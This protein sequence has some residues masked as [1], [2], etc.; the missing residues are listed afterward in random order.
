MNKSLVCVCAALCLA[1]VGCFRGTVS[2]NAPIHLNPNMDDQEKYEVYE[3]SPLF[4]DG[5]SMRMPVWG[6]LSNDE[7]AMPDSFHTGKNEK[8]QWISNPL[9]L[10]FE[11]MNRGQDR[12]NVYCSPCHGKV[13]D[14]KG[15]VAQRGLTQGFVPPTNFHSDDMRSKADGHY[16]DVITHGI[17][18]MSSY[19][20]QIPDPADRWAIVHYVRALQRS[21]HATEKDIP[22]AIE[23]TLGKGKP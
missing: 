9:E 21:K 2:E 13:G 19:S 6:T 16:F 10:S 22:D 8:G 11:V 12:F 4:E 5:A 18:N 20:Y 15:M 3:A 7:Q 1:M 14:G 17:R 23:K